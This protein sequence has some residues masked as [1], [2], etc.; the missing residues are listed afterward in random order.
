MIATLATEKLKKTKLAILKDVGSEYSIGLAK[1]FRAAIEKAGHTI[2]AEEVYASADKDFSKQLSVIKEAKPEAIYIPGYHQDLAKILA[3]A[4]K[5][6]LDTIYLGADGWAAPQLWTQG[7]ATTQES[8]FT[9]HFHPEEPKRAITNFVK[10]YRLKFNE[11]PDAFAALGYD[12]GQLIISAV[13]TISSTDLKEGRAA[14]IQALSSLKAHQG[15]TGV[16]NYSEQEI[17][18]K[19]T[20]VIRVGDGKPQFHWRSQP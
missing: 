18:E 14:L 13:K 16:I 15:V 7:L 3:D 1:T 9:S 2:V 10:A 5:M 8:Y 12:T 19:S 20:A 11:T 4:N 6:G 17:H